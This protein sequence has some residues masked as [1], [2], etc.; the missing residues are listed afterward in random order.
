MSI[1]L[2]SNF[3]QNAR[4]I[5]FKDGGGITWSINSNTNEISANG[6]GAGASG[7]NPTAKVGLAAVNGTDTTFMRSDAA[8][9]VDQSIAPTWT[10]A[11]TFNVGTVHKAGA[12]F[13]TS[14]TTLNGSSGQLIAGRGGASAAPT[15][16]TDAF[17]LWQQ[18]ADP[19][20]S[21]GV[22]GSLGLLARNVNAAGMN[23]VT[24]GTVRM[25]IAY[26]GAVVVLGEFAVNNGTPTAALSGFGS[27]SGS[28]TSG[29]TSSAT[30]AQ[31]AGTLAALLAYLKT[32][33]FIAA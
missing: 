18:N 2:K 11:H 10:G 5:T 22:A 1:S 28:V 13:G 20:N 6:S 23:F 27:P 33:G 7:A 26:G 12:L 3:L 24:G 21:Q 16:T 15:S 30:L 19:L 32:I 4:G 9:P 17:V 8:P 14:A 25:T 29:L 31:T